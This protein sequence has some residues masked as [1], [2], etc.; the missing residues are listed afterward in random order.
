M[1]QF[2]YLATTAANI[3]LIQDEVFSSAVQKHKD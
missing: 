3:I 1:A 2:K